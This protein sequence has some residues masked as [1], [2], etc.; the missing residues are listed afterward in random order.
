VGVVRDSRKCSGQPNIGR[1]HCAVI[2]AVA[3][4]FRMDHVNVYG[5]NL[6][7]LALPD[8]EII[9]IKFLGGGCE[10]SI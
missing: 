2:F 3:F 1:A 7:S 9:A 4:L 8:I 6:K 5:P 10:P